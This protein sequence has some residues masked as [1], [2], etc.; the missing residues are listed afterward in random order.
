M[1]IVERKLSALDIGFLIK[2]KP[3]HKHENMG[4]R[5]RLNFDII[6]IRKLNNFLA[7]TFFKLPFLN[8]YS[9]VRVFSQTESFSLIPT[10][11]VII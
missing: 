10:I 9:Y 3:I 8:I 6:I 5:F 11:T 1:V 7:Q 4:D 2:S